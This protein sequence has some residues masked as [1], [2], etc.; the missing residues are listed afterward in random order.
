MASC[1]LVN[2]R[3]DVRCGHRHPFVAVLGQHRIERVTPGAAI[4]AAARANEYG[5]PA[6][7]RTFTLHRRP[8]DFADWNPLGH[9]R[10]SA[11]VFG[12]S[13]TRTAVTSGQRDLHQS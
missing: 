12:V 1:Q 9:G 2:S 4:I 3:Q 10:Y 7:Q 13:L 5:W 11:Q 8:E 6:D